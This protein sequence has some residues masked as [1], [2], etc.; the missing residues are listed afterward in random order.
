MNTTGLIQLKIGEI[1]KSHGVKGEVSVNLAIDGM[2]LDHGMQFA[3]V[4]KDRKKC[5]I[6]KIRKHR[7]RL[8][9][10]FV[11]YD[12][13]DEADSLRGKSVYVLHDAL[14]DLCPNEFYVDN[15][16]GLDVITVDGNGLG[17]LTDVINTG[18]N[19]VYVVNAEDGKEILLP[20]IR[21]VVKKVDLSNN[22][23]VVVLIP[24]L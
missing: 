11:D 13:R 15:L 3:W 8:I 20:A 1:V 5:D 9:V 18:A 22:R 24:G 12:T 23:M 6:E 10:K 2:S 21:S 14:D 19:D 16:I 17:I 4:G 7:N